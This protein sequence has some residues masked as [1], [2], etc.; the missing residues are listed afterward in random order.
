M[1]STSKAKGSKFEKDLV[2]YLNKNLVSG[3]FKRIPT[4]GAIGT[5]INEPFLKGDVTGKVLGIPK[6]L[7]GEC[8]V[9]YGGVTQLAVKREW[10]NKIIDEAGQDYSI[11]FLAGKFSGARTKDGVQMF[12]ILDMETFVYLLNTIST[13]Q[14][15]LDEIYKEK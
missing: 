14:K 6:K 2:D 15:E 5:L 4:S 9:G 12:V 10:L 1:V 13:L 3:I 11:P 8:K 7:K